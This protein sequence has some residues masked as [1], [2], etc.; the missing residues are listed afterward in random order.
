MENKKEN[1]ILKNLLWSLGFLVILAL[2]IGIASALPSGPSSITQISSGRY[3]LTSAQN[4]SALAGNVSETNFNGNSI[5]NTWQGYF[6]NVSGKII[7]GDAN[8]KTFYDWTL[9]SARGKIYA[10]RTASVP[11]W[12]SIR[13][14]NITNVNTEDATLG[15]NQTSDLDSVNNTFLNLTTFPSFYVG[16]VYIN[17]TPG[18]YATKLYNSS[19]VKST[20]NFNEILL[21]DTSSLIYTGLLE[22]Q[23]TGYDNRTH[24]FE[25]LV[26]ENGHGSDT[27]VTPYYFYLELG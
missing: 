14:A 19:G 11:T 26:G 8:N 24:D 20:T 25:M 6:G 9:A 3:S 27:A 17:S 21:S 1:K 18:C 4:L 7:L 12:A 5:T 10:T 2:T 13:C 23:S 16:S 22:Q 15:T